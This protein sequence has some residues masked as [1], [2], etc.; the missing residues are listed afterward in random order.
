MRIYNV[1]FPVTTPS[2][3]SVA[4]LSF[5]AGS[6][7]TVMILEMDFE[8]MGN[9]AAN[10]EFAWYR[11]GAS[12]FGTNSNTATPTAIDGTNTAAS[13]TVYI[14]NTGWTIQPTFSTSSFNFFLNANGQRYFWRANPNLNNAICLDAPVENYGISLALSTG[15]PA[16]CLIAGR[17]QFAEI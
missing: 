13:T 15:T 12:S 3:S 5:V 6:A 9:V 7:K 10:A 11:W 2:A 14:G 1:R 17:V 8:G 16:N 4:L